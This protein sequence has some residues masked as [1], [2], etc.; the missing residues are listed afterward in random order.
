MTAV[1]LNKKFSSPCVTFREAEGGFVFIDIENERGRAEVSLYGGHILTFQSVGGLPV[2]WMSDDAILDRGTAIR[3]GIPICWPWFGS[4]PERDDVPSHGFA[5]ISDWSVESVDPL[6][7]ATRVV[8]TLSDSDSTRDM[9][10]YKFK[11]SLAITVGT[12]LVV[13]LTTENRGDD[14]FSFTQALHSYFT[15]GCIHDTS[16]IGLEGARYLDTVGEVVEKIQD[17]P[18]TFDGETDRDY[19]DTTAECTIQDPVLGR[20][21][22]IAKAGSNSTVVWNPWTEKAKGMK[23]FPDDAFPGML[24]VETTNATRF[25]TVDV[26]SGKAHTI[27]A[28]ISVK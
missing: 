26:Q 14:P 12:E 4:H 1:E 11:L 18:I 23:D 15:V 17:G 9:W 16:V 2:L 21:I 20:D 28:R 19:L 8:L 10:P 24:C 5:R 3:G 27:T 25:D 13:D 7:D 6:D 22:H